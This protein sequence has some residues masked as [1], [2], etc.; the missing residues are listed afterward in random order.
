MPEPL[1]K[2]SLIL[3]ALLIWVGIT[4]YPWTY[5][6]RFTGTASTVYGLSAVIWAPGALLLG[7]FLGIA[8]AIWL[9]PRQP[10]G[11]QEPQDS[12]DERV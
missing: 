2:V 3:G 4:W 7:L 9:W 5:W 8:F 1:R 10:R 12:P 6:D 11:A